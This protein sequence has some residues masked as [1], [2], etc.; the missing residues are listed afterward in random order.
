MKRILLLLVGSLLLAACQGIGGNETR[1]YEAL[2]ERDGIEAIT[3][4][5][6]YRIVEDERLAEP[7]RGIDVADFHQQ[8]SDQICAISNGPCTYTGRSMREAHEGMDISQTQFNAVVEHLVRAMEENNVGTAAQNRLL[9]R[10]VP[11][12]D[13]ITG[14]GSGD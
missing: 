13:E 14:T 10:L 3:E 11:M 12:H 1:L 4:T 9:A 5:M 8:F 2:G 6:L 7:F